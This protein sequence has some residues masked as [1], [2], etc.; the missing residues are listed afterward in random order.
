MQPAILHR[1][2]M[3]ARL[4]LEYEYNLVAA[5]GFYNSFKYNDNLGGFDDATFEKQERVDQGQ[6]RIRVCK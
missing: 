6:F 4:F 5:G 2:Q 1:R 3:L